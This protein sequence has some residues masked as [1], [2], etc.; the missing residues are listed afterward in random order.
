QST[1]VLA[2]LDSMA[3][4]ASNGINYLNTP[5]KITSA[6]IISDT[7]DGV[8]MLRAPT[9]VT[10]SY[11]VTVTA[12]DDGTNT[13]T[14][15]TFTVNVVADTSGAVANP[16]ASHTPSAPTSVAYEPSG[17][18]TATYTMLNNSSASQKLSFLVSGVTVNN[19]VTIYADGVAIGSATATST[20]QLV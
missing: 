16:W 19:L 10:G 9:G 4:H 14:T 2:A 11:T 17:K 7:Q 1:T 13:P 15:K 3:T 5:V 8:L 12:Y 6:S 18:A 20:S